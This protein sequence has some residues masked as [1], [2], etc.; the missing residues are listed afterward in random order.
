MT[1]RYFTKAQKLLILRRA[2]YRCQSCGILLDRNNFEADHLIP[3]S[4]GGFTK[5][6]NAQALCC[7]CNR[8]KSDT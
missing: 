6:F 1:G 2:D 3:Y 8:S 7:N 4:K 5:V